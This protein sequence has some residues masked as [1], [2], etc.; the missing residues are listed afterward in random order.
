VVPAPVAGTEWF[1]ALEGSKAQLEVALRPADPAQPVP[2][3]VA[4]D[5]AGIAVRVAALRPLAPTL[6]VLEA[7]G[8]LE[9]GVVAALAL[10]GLPVAVVNPRQVRDFAKATGQLAKTDAL[11]AGVLAHVAQV[12][13]PTPR[14]LPSDQQQALDALSTRRRQ[15]VD[16]LVAERNRLHTALPAARPSLQAHIAWLEQALGGLEGELDTLLQ[17]SLLWRERDQLLR[18]V[19]GVGPKT[20]Y[21]LLAEL[22]ELGQLSA[23]KVARLAGLAPLN[24]DTGTWRGSRHVWG[25]RAAVRKAL[26]LATLAAVRSNPAVQAF[27]QH[28]LAR[29]KANKVALTACMH[30]LLTILNAI[31]RHRTPWEP[32]RA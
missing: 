21:V 2:A 13:P 19:K 17:A 15:L 14:P 11:D 18:S 27:Y 16:R 1:V 24:R 23:R 6:V 10:A 20:A 30:Q 9:R 4:N 7:T 8:G 3:Q 25:G 32:A 22:P 29:G 31:L 28:L 26:Y 12:L 5:E